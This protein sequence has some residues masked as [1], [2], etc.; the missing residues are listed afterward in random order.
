MAM[1]ASVRRPQSSACSFSISGQV[2]I[3]TMLAHANPRIK[4]CTTQK[5]ATI[6]SRMNISEKR[7]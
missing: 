6:I 5:Q 1:I 2:A 3:T 4:G 7:I